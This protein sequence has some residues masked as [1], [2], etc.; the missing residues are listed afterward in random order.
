[1]SRGQG[2]GEGVDDTLLSDTLR[3]INFTKVTIGLV[4]LCEPIHLCV[5]VINVSRWGLGGRGLVSVISTVK[6]F[7]FISNRV[8]RF[9][10]GAMSHYTLN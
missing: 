3:Y 7:V 1:M 2:N 8:K 6:F 5:C 10:G 9:R 4:V